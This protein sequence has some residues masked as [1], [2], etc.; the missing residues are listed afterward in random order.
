[1]SYDQ[2][3]IASTLDYAVLKPTDD[4]V[5]VLHGC[6][7][8]DKYGFASVC[9]KPK[10]VDF[11]KENYGRISTVI[12]FP[13]GG[14]TPEVKAFEAKQAIASGVSEIDI[15]LD[16]TQVRNRHES[17]LAE[18][19]LVTDLIP[20]HVVVK[21]ILETCYLTPKQIAWASRVITKSGRAH[22]IKTSTGFGTRGASVDDIKIIK[23]NTDLEIKA[24]GGI[25]CYADVEKFLDLGC[26]RLGSSKWE[27]LLC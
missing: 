10:Y 15:V 22:F 4:K 6:Y 26:T 19:Y 21:V 18:L 7:L 11:A 2:D 14:T 17:Y 16:Y 20:R 24:S 3:K 27:E 23:A 1:M 12:G 5:D 13:H 8:A 9:V 25:N